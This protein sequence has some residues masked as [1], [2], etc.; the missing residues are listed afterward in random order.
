MFMRAVVTATG[1]VA[2]TLT[3]RL[4]RPTFHTG[5]IADIR[6]ASLL[7]VVFGTLTDLGATGRGLFQLS[8]RTTPAAVGVPTIKIGSANQGYALTTE[9]SFELNDELLLP[10][11]DESIAETAERMMRAFARANGIPYWEPEATSV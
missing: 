9:E 6:I 10:V 8:M 7:N 3:E 5:Q 4:H 11:T 2:A 1:T